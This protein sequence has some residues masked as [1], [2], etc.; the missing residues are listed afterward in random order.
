MFCKVY[1]FWP[2]YSKCTPYLK[3]GENCLSDYECSITDFCWYPD[4]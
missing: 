3:T 1:N 2:Y 4:A